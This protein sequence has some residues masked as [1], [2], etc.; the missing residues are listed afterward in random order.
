MKRFLA[1]IFCSLMAVTAHAVSEPV[2]VDADALYLDQD[3]KEIRFSGSVK[4]THKSLKLMAEELYAQYQEGIEDIDQVVAEGK[5]SVIKDNEEITGD[6]AS[7]FIKEQLLYLE[8]NVTYNR[9]GSLLKGE[10]LKYD[11]RQ[12]KASLMG[13]E[14]NRVRAEFTSDMIRGK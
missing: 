3:K 4:V 14:V 1:V 5:V 9:D 13:E 11:V 7:Y 8:G 10:K 6:K 12:G 2:A